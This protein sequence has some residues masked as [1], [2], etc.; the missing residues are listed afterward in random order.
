MRVIE[1][2]QIGVFL[3]MRAA[4]PVMLRNRRGS[5]VNIS[6]VQWPGRRRRHDRLHRLQV[7]RE[8][9]DQE[10][11]PLEYGKAGIRVNSVHPGA[12]DTPMT[13]A[14]FGGMREAAGDDAFAMNA[15]PRTAQPAEVANLV[16]FLASDESSFCTGAEYLVDGGALA[17]VV[18]PT[19]RA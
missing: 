1:V 14:I 12:I 7:R 13:Q 11:L 5:I 19:A 16:L 9:H 18:N 15:I 6:S 4:I 8:G 3:G 17:G 2:N 10:P